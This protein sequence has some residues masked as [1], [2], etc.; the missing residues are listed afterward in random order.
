MGEIFLG[1][2]P[3]FVHGA[4][5]LGYGVMDLSVPFLMVLF[6][7]FCSGAGVVLNAIVW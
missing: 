5:V 1:P 3:R 4:G 2:G 6:P 7:M